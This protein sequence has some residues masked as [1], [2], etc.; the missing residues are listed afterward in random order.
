VRGVLFLG[1]ALV[2]A[3]LSLIVSWSTQAQTVNRAGLVV[4]FGD[5]SVQTYCIQFTSPSITGYDLLQATGNLQV[6]YDTANSG[7]GAGVCKIN[8]DGCNYPLQDCFCQCQGINCVYWSYFHLNANNSFDYSTV[9]ASGHIL[10][11]GSVDGWR[12]GTGTLTTAPPPP[13]YTFDQ[14][15]N[16]ADTPTPTLTPTPTTTL[17][18]TPTTSGTPSVTPTRTQTPTPTFTPGVVQVQFTANPTTLAAGQ[19]TIVNWRVTG[20]WTAIFLDSAI[21]QPEEQRQVCPSQT[22]TLT[23]RAEYAGGVETRTVTLQVTA[24]GSP[25]AAATT[26][27]VSPTT[28]PPA[29]TQVPLPTTPAPT[30]SPTPAPNTATLTASPT[31]GLATATVPAGEMTATAT[32][33]PAATPIASS[34]PGGQVT[35]EPGVPVEQGDATPATETTGEPAEDVSL[36]LLQYALFIVILGLLGAVGVFLLWRRSRVNDE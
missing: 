24:A 4:Q 3:G 22:Q 30:D 10:Q 19:C 35:L 1:M 25:T 20:P 26:P 9:G 32:S 5:G 6:V 17:T 7:F 14:L 34:T 36:L 13:V 23:L 2:A 8:N 15:C 11:N 18:P 33:L 27:F 31:A 12:W 29:T 21:V 28:P 16:M